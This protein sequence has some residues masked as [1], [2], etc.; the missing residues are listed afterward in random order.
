MDEEARRKLQPKR[1]DEH[2]KLLVTTVNAVALICLGA[3]ALQ[4]IIV[5]GTRSIF[6]DPANGF[7]IGLGVA[8]H[9]FAQALIRLLRAE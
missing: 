7:W 4:P 3:G 6:S 8:L 5:S 1:F 9:M 2:V